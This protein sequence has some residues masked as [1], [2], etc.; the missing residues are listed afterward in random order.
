MMCGLG[1]NLSGLGFSFVGLPHFWQDSQ[2]MPSYSGRCQESFNKRVEG[3][4]GALKIRVRGAKAPKRRL[5]KARQGSASDWLG[6]CCRL[7]IEVPPPTNHF[8]RGLA[9]GSENQSRVCATQGFVVAY[10]GA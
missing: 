10:P 6:C 5:L 4:T 8:S 9:F 7:S 3:T 1:F 2:G